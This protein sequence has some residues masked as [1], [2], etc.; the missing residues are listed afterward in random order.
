MPNFITINWIWFK[1]T[2]LNMAIQY[3]QAA[4][5]LANN[6]KNIGEKTRHKKMLSSFRGAATTI[7]FINFKEYFRMSFQI[8]ILEEI[9]QIQTKY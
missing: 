6:K 1:Q 9:Y 4:E 5:Q 3:P 7:Y 2:F 8:Y